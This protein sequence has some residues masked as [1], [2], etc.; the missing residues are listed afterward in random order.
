MNSPD[1]SL[2]SEASSSAQSL[3]ESL[4]HHDDDAWFKTYYAVPVKKPTAASDTDLERCMYFD[5][6]WH[7]VAANALKAREDQDLVR[8][9]QVEYEAIPERVIGYIETEEYVVSK[10]VSLFSA[11][12][13]TLIHSPDPISNLFLAQETP[14]SDGHHKRYKSWFAVIPVASKT[15]RGV[16]LIFRSPAEGKP[17]KLI[18]TADPEV[19]GGSSN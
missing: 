9:Q 19:E 18:A 3:E 12:A 15:R 10:T 5:S 8:I 6:H 1:H 14:Y 16:I 4:R 7:P 17:V 11:N 2:A 13:L